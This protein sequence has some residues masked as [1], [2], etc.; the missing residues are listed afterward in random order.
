M[1]ILIKV[2]TGDNMNKYYPEFCDT[3]DKKRYDYI[4]SFPGNYIIQFTLSK[5]SMHT[6][7]LNFKM[8]N[9][10]YCA[11]VIYS[12]QYL[13]IPIRKPCINVCDRIDFICTSKC[14]IESLSWSS[15]AHVCVCAPAYKYL[16][17]SHLNQMR[18]HQSAGHINRYRGMLCVCV[19]VAQ[20][21]ICALVLCMHLGRI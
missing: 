1:G 5:M 9:P 17:I 6:C 8:D 10:I 11:K 14:T 15:F 19:C 16:H 12:H 4:K 13:Y 21:F 20:Y 3:V 2:I 18:H 7:A